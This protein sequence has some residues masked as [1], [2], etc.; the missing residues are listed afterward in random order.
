MKAQV[1]GIMKWTPVRKE[2]ILLTMA[3]P[4]AIS[5]GTSQGQLVR[6]RGYTNKGFNMRSPVATAKIPFTQINLQHCKAASD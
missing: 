6:G 4:N 5:K 3:E 1:M 2:G